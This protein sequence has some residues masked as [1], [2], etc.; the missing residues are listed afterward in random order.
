MQSHPLTYQRR[1]GVHEGEILLHYC[2]VVPVE[3]D[4]FFPVFV[5]QSVENEQANQFTHF[6]SVVAAHGDVE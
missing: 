5:G 6:C 1:Y 2:E 3:S 4:T